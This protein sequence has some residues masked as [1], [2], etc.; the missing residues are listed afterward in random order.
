MWLIENQRMPMP[1]AQQRVMNEFPSH[2]AVGAGGAPMP[3]MAMGET[4]QHVW[5]P[6]ANCDGIR[7]EERVLWLQQHEGLTYGAACQQV[8]REF[9][10]RF[11]V[12]GGMVVDDYAQTATAAYAT[13]A[14]AATAYASTPAMAPAYAMGGTPVYAAPAYG[15]PRHGHHH[16]GAG[17]AIGAGV[18][19]LAVGAVGGMMMENAIERERYAGGFAAPGDFVEERRDMFG[20]TDVIEERRDIFGGSDFTEVRTDVFGDRDVV[21]VRTDMFGNRDVTEVRTDMFGDQQITEVRT[22]MFGDREVIR[23]NVDAFGDV[24][25]EREDF[26]GF[27]GF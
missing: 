17:M 16:S 26:G 8:M 6:N 10:S 9:P 11:G 7:A 5:N 2:F 14:Y 20:G 19:G 18:A 27:G 4:T 25:Y 15:A 24:T 1:M 12:G 23:E 3:G 13:P 22:D 21:D